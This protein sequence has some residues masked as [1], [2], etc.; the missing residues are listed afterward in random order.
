MQDKDPNEAWNKLSVGQKI[1]I[2][3]FALLLAFVVLLVPHLVIRLVEHLFH[4]S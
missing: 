1:V 3:P 2:T 4:L